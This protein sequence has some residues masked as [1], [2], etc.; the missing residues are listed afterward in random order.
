MLSSLLQ[1]SASEWIASNELAFTVRAPSPLCSGHTLVALRRWVP[2]YSHASTAERAAVWVLVEQ[3]KGALEPLLRAASCEVGFAMGCVSGEAVPEAAVHVIPRPR[4][5]HS[6]QRKVRYSADP[7]SGFTA[8][9][10]ELEIRDC[11]ANGQRLAGSDD[12]SHRGATLYSTVR[13]R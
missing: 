2:S 6:A 13:D 10:D 5:A 1:L 9:C 3:V 4:D 12:P 8:C 7:F 11:R